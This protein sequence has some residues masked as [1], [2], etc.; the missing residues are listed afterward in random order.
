MRN[1][2]KNAVTF[3]GAAWKAVQAADNG[4]IRSGADALDALAIVAG[5][6]LE[7]RQALEKAE[8]EAAAAGKRGVAAIKA[9]ADRLREAAEKR[10]AEHEAYTRAVS[11]KCYEV[12]KIHPDLSGNLPPLMQYATG[13]ARIDG[14]ATYFHGWVKNYVPEVT[15]ANRASM[16][17]FKPVRRN[18]PD[19]SALRIPD[20]VASP[21]SALAEARTRYETACRALLD[22]LSVCEGCNAALAA[23]AAI[24][25]ETIEKAAAIQE[26]RDAAE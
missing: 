26:E 18:P 15:D 23:E 2:R 4:T 20:D 7:A 12:A 24:E 13:E 5:E 11:E 17:A 8:T 3:D 14:P 21:F 22:A 19:T 10:T 6:W 9:V 1:E 16:A 25:A